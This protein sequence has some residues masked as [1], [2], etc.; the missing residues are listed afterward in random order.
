MRK[1]NRFLFI[2]AGIF[3]LWAAL[4][5]FFLIQSRN[6]NFLRDNKEK[7][8]TTQQDLAF[9]RQFALQYFTYDS[10]NFWQTQATL[11]NLMTPKLRAR[12]LD[13]IS[14][15]RERS[16]KKS[17][18]QTVEIFD[19]KRTAE[20]VYEL[21]AKVSS[22]EEARKNEI[23][24]HINLTLGSSEPTPENP[25]NYQVIDILV[26]SLKSSASSIPLNSVTLKAHQILTLQFPC[27]IEN[28]LGLSAEN[29][30]YKIVTTQ[31]SEIQLSLR[32]SLVPTQTVQFNCEHQSFEITIQSTMGF[33]S[34]IYKAIPLSAARPR[35]VTRKKESLDQKERKTLE[36]EL[37]FMISE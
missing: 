11:T 17:F 36:T 22:Y 27:A 34:D 7:G 16:S 6:I 23:D 32:Q 9:L 5:T 10:E 4:A 3:F 29:W 28:V 2:L 20:Q 35:T 37:N 26:K 8:Q 1:S 14:L 18:R 21:L 31:T 30:D 13:E 12:R 24:V 33:P 19:I 15:L 25:W